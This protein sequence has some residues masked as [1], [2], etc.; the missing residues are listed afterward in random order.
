MKI[1]LVHNEIFICDLSK[2]LKS[3]NIHFKVLKKFPFY[4]RGGRF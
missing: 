2:M 4:D 3:M 1:K